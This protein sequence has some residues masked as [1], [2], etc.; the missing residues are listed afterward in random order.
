ME[1]KRVL[2]HVLKTNKPAGV[3]AADHVERIGTNLFRA[4]CERDCE[5]IV[6]KHRRTPYVTEPAVWFKV[7]NPGYTQKRGRREMFDRFHERERLQVSL[8]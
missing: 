3:F 4:V 7:L 6:A 5:G 2:H 8:P 1:R